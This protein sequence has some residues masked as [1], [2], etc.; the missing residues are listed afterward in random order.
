MYQSPQILTVPLGYL[1]ALSNVSISLI[2]GHPDGIAT[3]VCVRL[4]KEDHLFFTLYE[5]F[6]LHINRWIPGKLCTNPVTAYEM[7]NE[8]VLYEHYFCCD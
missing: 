4:D 6:S 3:S 5:I 2:I 7:V 1:L 8:P